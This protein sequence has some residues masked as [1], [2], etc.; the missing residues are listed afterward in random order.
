MESAVQK[1]RILIVE[2]EAAI[3]DMV[4][5]ALS[6]AE[7]QL[8]EAANVEQAEAKL[9]LKL[10]DI[11]LLDW[12]LPGKSGVE[13]LRW[14]KKQDLLQDIPVIMLTAKAEEESKVKGLQTGAD[15]YVTKPF[16]PAELIARIRAVL[17]RGTLKSPDDVVTVGQ[18]SLSTRTH[19]VAVDDKIIALAPIEYKILRFF[20]THPNRTYTRDQLINQVWGASIYIEDR[21]VDV[22]IRRL[23]DQLK[24]YGY[25]ENI[26]TIRSVGYQFVGERHETS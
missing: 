22:Q 16:S 6:E 4:R 13:F 12:M 2:D 20:M 14:L 9:K 25:H 1:I 5:F 3:R 15:D 21:T 8:Y 24:P 19:Q 26:K 17:R 11:I 18:L 23:R 7:F 10:P